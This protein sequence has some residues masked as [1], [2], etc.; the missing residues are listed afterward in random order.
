M[1]FYEKVVSICRGGS[2]RLAETGTFH[3]ALLVEPESIIWG[4]T[5]FRHSSAPTIIYLEKR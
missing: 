4:L 5:R 3:C 2:R 1:D